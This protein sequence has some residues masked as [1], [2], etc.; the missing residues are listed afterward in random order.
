MKIHL[1]TWLEENQGETLTK[2]GA[3]NR[4]MSYFFIK[5][6]AGKRFDLKEYVKKGKIKPRKEK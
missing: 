4:L 6:Y 3:E 5:D 2:A 1:A